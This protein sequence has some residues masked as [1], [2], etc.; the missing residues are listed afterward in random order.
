MKI[1]MIVLGVNKMELKADLKQYAFKG[2][3]DWSCWL[4]F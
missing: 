2:V 4:L 1:K 3:Y